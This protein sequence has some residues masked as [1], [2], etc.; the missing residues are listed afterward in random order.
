MLR[1]ARSAGTDPWTVL[2]WEPD[3][4]GFAIDCEAALARFSD[5]RVRE[6]AKAHPLGVVPAFILG[7]L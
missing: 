2:T 1:I 7:S 3:R 5:Q 4:L 6:T